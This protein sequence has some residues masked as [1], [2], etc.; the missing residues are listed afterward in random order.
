MYSNFT[1]IVAQIIDVTTNLAELNATIYLIDDPTHLN[2]LVL[3]SSLSDDYCDFTVVTTWHN[4]TLEIYDNN[5]LRTGPTS[6]LLSPI[7][8]PLMST[9]GTH[10][11]SVFIDGG[12]DS[13]WYNISY[14]V[15]EIIAFTVEDWDIDLHLNEG[16]SYVEVEVKTTWENSTIYAYDN[17]VLMATAPESVGGV[18]FYWWM[19][20]TA[21]T[22][23]IVLNIT[24][25]STVHTRTKSYYI[26]EWATGGMVGRYD[27]EFMQENTTMISVESNWGNTTAYV[28][29]DSVLAAIITDDPGTA[30]W[31]RAENHGTFNL[32]IIWDGGYQNYTIVGVIFTV[33]EEGTTYVTGGVQ[34]PTYEGPTYEGDTYENPPGFYITAETAAI[35]AVSGVFIAFLAYLAVDR[36]LK[37]KR[38]DIES[39]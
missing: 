24:H 14:T 17:G 20:E 3:G 7:R 22:H 8:Y 29:L 32:T 11:L 25:G 37:K 39:E 9:S 10:N 31:D 36:L 30:S 23:D 12:A 26:P 18:S 2:P 1:A 21:G 4:A 5:V 19:S 33:T 13:F 28:Y 6:E 35:I 27:I 38:L 34:Y 15:V 16:G